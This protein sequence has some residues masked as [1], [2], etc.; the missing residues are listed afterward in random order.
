MVVPVIRPMRAGD[1]AETL[2]AF[3]S[4]ADEGLWLGTQPGFDR[5]ARASAW[6][7]GLHD[8]RRRSLLVVDPDNGQIVGNGSLHLAGY[9]VAEVGMSLVAAARGRGF[10]RVLLDALIEA[11]REL[12]AH[13][14]ELQVWPHNTPAVELYLSRGFV[15]EGRIRAHYRRADGRLWDAILMGL[16]LDPALADRMRGS[17][18]PDAPGLPVALDISG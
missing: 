11:S 6:L 16:L 8:P 14:V 10:G 7:E 9:G 17:G 1:V 3:A 18:L 2:A 4:V 12:G 5:T 15:V 13:K